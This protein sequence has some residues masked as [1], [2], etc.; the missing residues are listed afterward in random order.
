MKRSFLYVL[1]LLFIFLGGCGYSTRS[2]SPAIE[3]I[4]SIHV[5]PFKNSTDYGSERGNKN[6]YIPMMEVKITTETINRFLRDGVFKVV[7]PENADVIL[8][9]ELLNYQRDVLREDD[10]QDITEY[11]ISIVVSLSLT[12]TSDGTVMWSEPSFVGETTYFVTGPNAKSEST[13]IDDALKD[14]AQRILERTVED[15]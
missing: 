9:G 13:A 14:L 4:N 8:K 11:R 5:M 12:K 10:N 3:G 15:W 1:A 2:L 6:I 7:K